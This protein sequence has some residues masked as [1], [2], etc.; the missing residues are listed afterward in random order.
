MAWDLPQGSSAV[1]AALNGGGF[2]SASAS[3]AGVSNNHISLTGLDTVSSPG[4]MSVTGMSSP[5][6]S[7]ARPGSATNNNN[8][9]NNNNNNNS[10]VLI[11]RR[12]GSLE[13]PFRDTII[14]LRTTA[15]A[16]PN[17]S[18]VS[19]GVETTRGS[20]TRGSIQQ[21]RNQLQQRV[22]GRRMP[23]EQ[24]VAAGSETAGG[25][26]F[27]AVVEESMVMRMQNVEGVNI[28][29]AMIMI[30]EAGPLPD[31]QQP[32]GSGPGAPDPDPASRA[33][34][35][36]TTGSSDSEGCPT[37]FDLTKTFVTS[38]PP[39]CSLRIEGDSAPSADESPRPLAGRAGRSRSPRR[40]STDALQFESLP[41]GL[42]GCPTVDEDH[43]SRTSSCE[44][45]ESRS[46]SITFASLRV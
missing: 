16:M 37:F 29:R 44:T 3:T 12:S 41:L 7:L 42:V 32:P 43:V 11:R 14:P 17:E 27:P 2:R 30:D 20:T 18:V 1:M 23:V 13:V 31:A 22:L 45:A 21:R 10:A 4:P 6:T 24:E 39:P 28:F 5:F 38:R 8:T 15:T 9:I 26:G 34:R 25:V 46:D 36:S 40:S 19:E 35:V 33:P